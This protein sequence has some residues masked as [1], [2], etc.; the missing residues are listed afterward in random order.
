MLVVSSNNHFPQ[1]FLFLQGWISLTE[2]NHFP[3]SWREVNQGITQ[4]SAVQSTVGAAQP[5]NNELKAL[6]TQL[7]LWGDISNQVYTNFAYAFSN[8]ADQNSLSVVEWQNI[9]WPSMVGSKSSTTTSIH[10]PQRQ[11]RK[12]K[13]PAYI[14]GLVGSHS[15]SL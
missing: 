4:I 1:H 9:S 5:T 3:N 6:T 11:N 2:V 15:W 10:L 7:N 8:S 14:S 13:I 12:W